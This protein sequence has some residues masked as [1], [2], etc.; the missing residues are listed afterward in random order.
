MNIDIEEEI[1]NGN[2]VEINNTEVV[3]FRYFTMV[4]YV[5][6]FFCILWFIL[7]CVY[8]FRTPCEACD[9][10]NRILVIAI[11]IKSI[12][13]LKIT[14]IRIKLRHEIE[15]DE[16]LKNIM[17]SLIKLF[18]FLTFF[19]SLLSL[20]LLHFY[21][22]ICTTNTI[23]LKIIRIYYYFTITLYFI[24]LLFYISLG[25]FLSIIICIMIN[26]SVDETDRIPTPEYIIK[27]LKVMRYEDIN[28]I[29][30][31]RNK[32]G[33][34]GVKTFIKKPSFE[35]IIDKV[36][37]VIIDKDNTQKNKQKKII[38]SKEDKK[39][40][41][42]EQ[43]Y[44]KGKELNAII[45]SNIG[46]ENIQDMLKPLNSLPSEDNNKKKNNLEKADQGSYE[47]IKIYDDQ[48]N[49]NDDDIIISSDKDMSNESQDDTNNY[50]DHDNQIYNQNDDV[51]S[52][53]MMNY[54]N[55]DDV[56]IMPCDKRHFFHVNC[57]TK[58]LYK[59]QVCPICRTNIVNCINSKNEIV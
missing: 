49:D 16:R 52:I 35:L 57:L 12:A 43:K 46:D 42:K 11:L 29:H 20:Y 54:I 38:K 25:L 6:L 10:F 27:K 18:N 48:N 14:I 32:N 17:I 51:C 33:N 30:K 47:N 1:S 58:W 3:I 13:H 39:I 21:K 59:S 4:L 31:K 55:K 26:F 2:Y 9:V 50:S 22:N 24:P 44:L 40:K 36:K 37:S 5:L 15:N 34:T 7:M 28:Y 23:S 53:C 19:L 8:Y 56:M 41:K 45:N